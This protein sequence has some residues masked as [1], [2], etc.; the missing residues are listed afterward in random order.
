MV[1]VSTNFVLE[2]IV[3]KDGTQNLQIWLVVDQEIWRFKLSNVAAWDKIPVNG[4]GFPM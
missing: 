1:S 2:G 4:Y 3:F